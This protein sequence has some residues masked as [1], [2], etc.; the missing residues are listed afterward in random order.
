[1]IEL[2]DLPV[3]SALTGALLILLVILSAMVT[4]RRAKLGG[5]QFG[6]N[7]DETLRGRI[8]AHGNFVEIAPLVILGIGLMEYGGAP[9]S[10]LWW[11]AS[12]FLLGRILHAARMYI[13]N[14]FIGLFS[15]I[16]QHVICL[17][18]GGWLISN[19]IT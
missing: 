1:M 2:P 15:I 17:W 11:F 10:M 4:A 19:L 7:D 8:R 13:G 3:T 5:I 9:E 16:S 18:A 6:D 14:P 12:I